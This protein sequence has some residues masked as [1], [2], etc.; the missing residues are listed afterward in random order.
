[1]TPESLMTQGLI[2]GRGGGGGIAPD[3]SCIELAE[4][5]VN[6]VRIRVIPPLDL[7]GYVGTKIEYGAI[8]ACEYAEAGPE[9]AQD[10]VSIV[11]LT[12]GTIYVF[13]PVAYGLGGSRAKPGNVIMATVP[14][15][16]IDNDLVS[17]NSCGLE[18]IWK[19]IAG[20]VNASELRRSIMAIEQHIGQMLV[21]TDDHDRQLEVLQGQ[22]VAIRKSLS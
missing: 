18:D 17:L 10:I 7:S 2:A 19:M 16:I 9:D 14:V 15:N 22:I 4:V 13:V 6:Y 11:P 5:G 12:S 1:M 21:R 20:K 3:A 8:G